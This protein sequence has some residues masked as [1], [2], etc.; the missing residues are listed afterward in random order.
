M[1]RPKS[2]DKVPVVYHP[3]RKKRSYLE[4]LDVSISDPATTITHFPSCDLK[5]VDW[6]R[7][8]ERG[9]WIRAVGCAGI[10]L[11][12]PLLVLFFWFTINVGDGSLTGM[13]KC[14]NVYVAYYICQG[15]EYCQCGTLTE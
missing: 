13:L 2:H 3:L 14:E 15:P 7:N 11:L 10:I 9:T 1:P 5:K 4:F 8:S 6:G 12:S